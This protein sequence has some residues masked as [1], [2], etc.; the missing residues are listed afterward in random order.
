M[1]LVSQETSLTKAN[2]VVSK[3]SRESAEYKVNPISKQRTTSS[4]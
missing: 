3:E 4:H 2:S 1:T